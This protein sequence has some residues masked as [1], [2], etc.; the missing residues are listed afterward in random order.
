MN[1]KIGQVVRQYGIPVNSLYFY[2]NDGLLVPPKRNKQYVF[3]ERTIEDL[4]WILELKEMKFPLKTIH[5]LL[6]LRRISN[7]CSLEDREERERI[8]RQQDESLMREEMEVSHARRSIHAKLAAFTRDNQQSFQTGVPL[9]SLDLLCC[10]HCNEELM[11]D[12]ARM[13]QRYVFEAKLSCRCGY[14]A[15]IKDGILQTQNINTS[16]YDKPDTTRELY[17]DL[18]SKTLSLFEQSYRWLENKMEHIPHGK[19]WV[20][21]YVNAWFFFHN[22]I[23]LLAKNDTLIVLDKF[24]ETLLAYKRVIESQ[25]PDCSILYVADASMTPPLKKGIIDCSMDFFATNEHNFYH[26]DLYLDRIRPYLKEQSLLLGVYF[27][28]KKGKQSIQ[29]LLK[30]YPEASCNNFNDHWFMESVKQHFKIT[31]TEDCGF[32]VNSGENLGLGFHVPGEELHL[33]PYFATVK[34]SFEKNTDI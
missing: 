2:I 16:I 20:E 27:H 19:V 7:F 5:R 3:D 9:R 25:K 6:S 13:N 14:A 26:P 30:D 24:P 28:F 12:D 1:M 31:D 29:K 23:D 10:P 32:S 4:E 8:F 21:G 15:K 33:Q 18:P 22:H 11:L 34:H 17:R